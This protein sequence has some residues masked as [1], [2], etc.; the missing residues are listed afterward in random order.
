MEN[1]IIR[2]YH[3]ADRETCRE[4]CRE[5]AFDS[6]KKNADKLETVPVM[7]MDYFI[8]QEPENVFVAVNESN[9]V[10][11]YI[12]CATNY[13][14]FITAMKKIY[15]PRAMKYDRHQ[16]WFM[17]M[18]RYAL[19]CVRKNPCH[20]HIDITEKYQHMGI[21]KKLISALIQHL[22][23]NGFSSLLIC[24]VSR[25]SAGYGFYIKYGFHEIKSY[26]FG[27]VSLLIEF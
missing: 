20:M 24:A 19:F 10:V 2:P 8:E 9:R 7:F 12:I 14:K 13:K 16:Y 25:K 18:V 15:T 3:T 21:G 23:E 26:G 11:G 27:H 1:I 17:L 5:T 22:K 6:Y 4:I